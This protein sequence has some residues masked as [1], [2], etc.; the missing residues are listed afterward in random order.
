MPASDTSASPPSVFG[1][2]TG[3]LYMIGAAFFWSWMS[4]F[5]KAVGERL[6]SQQIVL[7]RAVVTL[8]YSYLLIRW[9]GLGSPW[10][11]NKRLLWLR[12]G[13]GFGALSCFFFALTKLPLA[14]ATVL[15]YTNPVWTAL[16]A[17]LALN[18]T[19]SASDVGGALLSLTGVVFIAQPSF[20]FGGAV[21]GL[22]LVYV[23][24]ALAGA[25]LSASA[26]VLVRKLRESEHP[27]VIVFYFPLVS[28]LG[29]TPT[30]ALTGMRWPT[31]W[32]WLLLIVGVGVCAQ[33]AQ[34]CV[35]KGLH[36]TKAGRAM[37]ISYLQIVFAA[38]WGLLLFHEVPDLW[39]LGGAVLVVVGTILTAR[40]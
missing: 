36:A 25:V 4:V 21:G 9:A 8:T 22:N 7:V 35:T 11:T 38:A 14:D 30:A 28:T 16:I 18:E 19:L 23:G 34:V 26:Y 40:G 31:G 33:V 13:L 17:A 15:H 20:L 12:G 2:P 6:P 27:L 5:V 1:V 32:E 29:S 3:I 10:G 37:S 24:V 39:S